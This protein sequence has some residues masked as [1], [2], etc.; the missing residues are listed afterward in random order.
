[1]RPLRRGGGVTRT[2]P[3]AALGLAVAVLIVDQVVKY[4]VTGPLGLNYLSAYRTIT[5]FFDLRYVANC[6]VSLGLLHG[7][8]AWWPW[9]LVALTGAISIGVFVWMLREKNRIDQLALGAVLGGALGNIADRL[10]RSPRCVVDYADLH[11]GDWRP[12]L[13]FNVADVAITVGVATLLI[14]AF[15]VRDK[16]QPSTESSHA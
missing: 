13:V 11:I 10:F 8:E 9:V 6:G 16:R 15:L 2:L 5:S 12:F 3:R 1:V 4:W 14:R 7:D